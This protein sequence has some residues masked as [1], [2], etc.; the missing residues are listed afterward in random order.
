MS[1]SV[2]DLQEPEQPA[3]PQPQQSVQGS[4]KRALVFGFGNSLAPGIGF[5]LLPV[6]TRALS[7]SSYGPLSVLLAISIAAGMLFSFGLD[8]GLFRS[9][10]QYADDPATQRRMLGSIWRFL[11]IAP[12]T[13]SLV[14]TAVAA[15]FVSSI[16][17]V[18]LLDVFLA[19]V[20]G[21]LYASATV[22]PMVVMRVQQRLVGFMTIAGVNGIATTAFVFT[23]VVLLH[24]GITGWLTA[25]AA[26][27]LVV[28]V[29]AV[30]AVPWYR[31]PFDRA[32]LRGPIR[33]GLTLIP[34]G[35]ALWAIL[36]ADRVVL[37]GLVSAHN[38]GLYSLASNIAVPIG[39]ANQALNQAL[40][41]SYARAGLDPSQRGHLAS[42]I[43]LQI[44]FTVGTM[45]TGALLGGPLV[46]V[47]TAPSYHAAAPLVAWIALANGLTGLYLIPMNGATIG[48]GRSTF[49]WAIS[50]SAALVNVV[51]LVVWVPSGGIHAAAI[52]Y[53]I[54]GLV[55][56][57]GISLYSRG[58]RNPNSYRWTT[59]AVVVCGGIA[60]YVAAVLTTSGSATTVGLE[61]IGWLAVFA[62]FGAITARTRKGT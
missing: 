16:H 20:S 49:I 32:L 45:L 3:P 51:L 23:A 13:A 39:F 36:L 31:E 43:S 25:A 60:V 33:F 7:P 35:F 26:S 44:L 59:I 41:P 27:N 22:V 17:H 61:R 42:M 50:G 46:N 55:L 30:L 8:L 57:V 12:L 9:F 56:L 15:P 2:P 28:L 4:L 58:E 47:L 37:A 19:L 48:A 5:L 54:T 62:V 52:A 11:I 34:H 14:I 10:F 1:V 38:L 53:A 24:T 21:A 40:Q 29:T 6:Y 18:S